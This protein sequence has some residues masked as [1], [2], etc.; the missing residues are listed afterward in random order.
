MK[1]RDGSELMISRLRHTEV[2]DIRTL[3]ID[4][5]SR[6]PSQDL[7][8]MDDEEY[9][10]EHIEEKGEIYGAYLDGNLAAYSVL[11]FPGMSESNLGRAFGVPEKE[12]PR[13]AVLD[14]TVV[15]ESVRGLGLQRC[16]HELRENRARE[17]DYLYLYSTVHPRNFPSIKNLEAAGFILQF[18]R[19][20]YGGKTRHCYSKRLQT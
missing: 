9:I 1:T 15:H 7:F 11:A 8:A 4:V 2:K 5:V 6:L 3:M 14:S 10:H 12:L 18:S 20:M 17:K 16:F 13:V 19:P